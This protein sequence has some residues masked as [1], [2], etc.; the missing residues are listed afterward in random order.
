MPEPKPETPAE[1]ATQGGAPATPP[2][3]LPGWVRPALEFGPLITF[4]VVQRTTERL[5][6]LY[7]GDHRLDDR[8]GHCGASLKG[9]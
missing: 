7:L 4:F 3:V 5:D 1:P 8:H 2:P 6:G 9:I